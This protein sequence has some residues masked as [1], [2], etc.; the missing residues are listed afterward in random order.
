MF[1]PP[2]KYCLLSE[3]GPKLSEFWNELISSYKNTFGLTR[4]LN[5]LTAIL[6]F[7]K[8]QRKTTN[9]TN[10]KNRFVREPCW[11]SAKQKSVCKSRKMFRVFPFSSSCWRTFG[12]TETEVSE[13]LCNYS[14]ACGG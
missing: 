1:I 14:A 11:F 9:Q 12:S 4:P 6:G 13:Q 8:G 7:N 3:A 10:R 2:E 5:M